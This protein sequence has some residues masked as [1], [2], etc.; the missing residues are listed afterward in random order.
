MA[1]RFSK[2]AAPFLTQR[3]LNNVNDG[4]VGGSISSAPSGLNV[5]QFEQNIPGDRVIFTP[6][7]AF[8]YANNSVGNLYTGTYRYVSFRNNSTSSPTRARAAFW[9]PTGGGAFTG[10]NIGSGGAN[11]ADAT[12]IVTSDGNAANYTNTLFAGVYINNITVAN[13]ANNFGWIQ[14]SGKA[15][16]KFIATLTGTPAIGVPVYLGLTAAANNNATDNGA[17]DVLDGANSAAIFTA[18]STTGYTTVGAMINKYV[19]VAETA[20]SNNNI[21]L[22]DMVLNRASYRW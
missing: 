8:A 11:G 5:S 6:A 20:P 2:Q 14:E 19:G 13:T 15:S 1:G 4:I 10:N 18:N 21:S 9:D 16:L 3:F 17:F 22:V 12:Y 7:D